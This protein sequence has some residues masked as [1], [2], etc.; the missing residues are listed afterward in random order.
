MPM[1]FPFQFSGMGSQT[2]KSI[3]ESLVGAEKPA[4]R[5]KEVE[6]FRPAGVPKRPPVVGTSKSGGVWT[7]LASVIVTFSIR[8]DAKLSHDCCADTV[9]TNSHPASHATARSLMLAPPAALRRFE[10]GSRLRSL[11]DFPSSVADYTTEPNSEL[12]ANPHCTAFS[13][14]VFLF[15]PSEVLSKIAE[16]LPRPKWAYNEGEQGQAPS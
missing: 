13:T 2:S 11:N 14:R 12:E 9:G 15:R 3:W 4:T 1:Y 8:S 5:Q 6:T 7:H 10:R 16:Q